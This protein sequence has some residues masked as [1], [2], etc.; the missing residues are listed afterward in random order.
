MTDIEKEILRDAIEIAIK[1][2]E[3]IVIQKYVIAGLSILCVILT[4][5]IYLR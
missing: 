5:L 3:K 1:N 4:C 2:Q